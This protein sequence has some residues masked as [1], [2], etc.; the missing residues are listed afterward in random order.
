VGS[1]LLA[2]SDDQGGRRLATYIILGHFTHLLTL[3]LNGLERG[4][5]DSQEGIHETMQ[6]LPNSILIICPRKEPRNTE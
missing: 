6:P 5:S 2:K 4:E 3:T 1:K